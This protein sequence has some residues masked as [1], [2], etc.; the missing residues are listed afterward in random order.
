LESESGD[1]PG[2]NDTETDLIPFLHL[3]WGILEPLAFHEAASRGVNRPKFDEPAPYLQEESSRSLQG[4]PDLEP[5]R[6][7][8]LDAGAD[9]VGPAGLLGVNLFYRPA[10]EQPRPRRRLLSV[11]G[12][13]A[14]DS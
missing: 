11:P 13:P 14:F 7:W 3:L 12:S 8:N 1:G 5:T 4:N 9:L 2:R 6:S 10:G